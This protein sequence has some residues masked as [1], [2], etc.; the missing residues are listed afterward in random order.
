MLSVTSGL[1]LLSLGLAAARDNKNASLRQQRR[2]LPVALSNCASDC[3]MLPLIFTFRDACDTTCQ[4]YVMQASGIKEGNFRHLKGVQI[5]LV[6]V[7]SD[8]E[9]VSLQSDVD[10]ASIECDSCITI[11]DKD[12]VCG[13]NNVTYINESD[14]KC[15]RKCLG[16]DTSVSVAYN[17]KCKKPDGTAIEIVE[18]EEQVGI[19]ITLQTVQEELPLENCDDDCI[20]KPLIL[21]FVRACDVTCVTNL[22]QDSGIEKTNYDHLLSSNI[23]F[24]KEV[25]DDQLTALRNLPERKINSME[26]DQC[27][28]ADSYNPVCSSLNVTYRNEEE[29]DC[30]LK[31]MGADQTVSIA[32]RA[33]CGTAIQSV[34]EPPPLIGGICFSSANYIQLSNGKTKQMNQLRLGDEVLTQNDRY[35]SVYSWSHY[36]TQKEARFI[37]LLPSGMEL[38][39]NHLLFLDNGLAVPAGTIKAGDTLLS[40]DVVTSVRSVARRGIYAPFTKS[41]TIVVQGQI[42]STF[43]SLQQESNTLLLNNGWSTGITHQWLA[44]A[45]EAPH[46]LWCSTKC[47]EES[48]TADGISTWV[49]GPLRFFTWS[50]QLPMILQLILLLP[51]LALFA[52]FVTL[53][54][55]VENSF[56]TVAGLIIGT[57]I[58]N[59]KISGRLLFSFKV[60]KYNKNI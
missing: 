51:V 6:D 28:F 38:S 53:E 13:S 42:A 48:Y 40:G 10:V 1:L 16:S 45:F 15:D 35:E 55:A 39:P 31:C 21:T 47:T 37:Q 43:V 57:L 56:V 44:H 50:L 60:R 26:C 12:P 41:G 46:R 32:Q 11:S 7:V 27:L 22:M 14:L 33:A 36:N 52:M 2:K 23:V 29:F 3:T 59:S 5:I 9:I 20:T 19:G 18:E 58:L 34:E 25:T 24:L 49:A 8:S 30:G 17:G 54:L 4:D